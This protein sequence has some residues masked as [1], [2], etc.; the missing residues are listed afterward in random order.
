LPERG[1]V[2]RAVVEH[3]RERLLDRIAQRQPPAP[4]AP[5]PAVPRHRL[6]R[7]LGAGSAADVWEAEGPDGERVALKLFHAKHGSAQAL[8]S[9][10]RRELRASLRLDHPGIVR[11]LD[12]GQTDEGRA[13]LVMELLPGVDLGRLLSREGRLPWPRART[14][15]LQLC[16]AMSVAHRHG[17]IHRDLKPANLM[18]GP[19]RDGEERCTVVD[20]GLS[21]LLDGS[22][23]SRTDGTL[24]GT[25]AYMSPEQIRG[26]EVDHRA[27]VYALG[28]IAYEMLTAERPFQGQTPGECA[29]QHLVAP[30]PRLRI[31]GS[32]ARRRAIDAVI[33]R[34]LAK[35]PR[36]RFA[37][38]LELAEALRAVD[39]PRDRWRRPLALASGAV[40]AGAG[41]LAI[42]EL[43]GPAPVPAELEASAIATP[44]ATPAANVVADDAHHVVDV[45]LALVHTCATARDGRAVCWGRDTMGRLGRGTEDQ[46]LGDNETPADVAPL[47]LEAVERIVT[48][49]STRHTCAL[50]RNGTLRCFGHGAHGALGR[51][52]T[53][54]FGDDADEYP[55]SL[56][57]LPLGEVVDVVLGN[58]RTCAI[59]RDG[60][61]RNLYCWGRAEHGAL[62][63]G[64]TDDMGDDESLVGLRPVPLGADVLEAASGNEHTCARLA[65]GSVRCWGS[66]AYGQLGLPGWTANVGDGVGNGAGS[67]ER[68]DDP[69]LD[70]QGLAGVEIVAIDAAGYITCVLTRTGGARCWGANRGGALGYPPEDLPGCSSY[71]DPGACVLEGPLPFDIDL[72]GARAVEITT[73]QRH[74]CVLDDQGQVRCWGQAENGRLGDGIAIDVGLWQ[75]PAQAWFG[76][77]TGGVVDVG[78]A[79]GDGAI[80]PVAQVDA[81]MTHTCARMVAGGLRCWGTGGDGC[82]GYGSADSVGITTS[83]AD[84]YMGRGVYDVPVFAR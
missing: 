83:P 10:Q 29:I 19:G 12:H 60:E 63:S 67:G 21:R 1:T 43:L 56:P 2:P 73:G 55:G 46:T 31:P 77:D 48:S 34:A 84:E 47:Q 3:H 35:E 15:L 53:D 13:F 22:V 74:V 71:A 65:T 18:V 49:P 52:S 37:D 11:V 54:D 28:C 8:A 40:L 23:A 42:A 7:L 75:S 69:D 25:P 81:G 26:G 76:R 6:L 14:L 9:S 41:L 78:D 32:R 33:R 66:D 51:A 70:V 50:H 39:A 62:G 80:D 72:G 38:V 82:L 64:S 27:D 44:A 24:V 45:S 61:R 79:D 4:P 36:R 30:P 68:P 17:V 16:E 20:L 58:A 57:T 5:P 59:V